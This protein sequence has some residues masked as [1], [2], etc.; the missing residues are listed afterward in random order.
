MLSMIKYLL[1]TVNPVNSFTTKIT[2][3]LEKY[4]NIDILAMGFPADW[5]DEEL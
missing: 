1:L 3:L 4:P 2:D 5:R